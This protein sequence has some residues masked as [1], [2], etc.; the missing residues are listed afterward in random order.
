MKPLPNEISGELKDILLSM[1]NMDADK[2]P[3]VQQLLS[4]KFFYIIAS[5][6]KQ[7]RDKEQEKIKVEQENRKEKVRILQQKNREQEQQKRETQKQIEQE[8]IKNE[9]KLEQERIKN[10]EKLEQERIKNEELARQ[11]QQLKKEAEEHNIEDKALKKGLISP[12]LLKIIEEKLKIPLEGTEKE[13]KEILDVQESKLQTL[14]TVIKQNQDSPN[15]KEVIT[16][17]VI[18]ELNKILKDRDLNDMQSSISSIFV[19]LTTSVKLEVILLLQN[20]NPFPGLI[21]L[22]KHPNPQVVIDS[23]KTIYNILTNSSN[24]TDPTSHHPSFCMLKQCNGLNGIMTLF[25]ANISKESKDLAAISLSHVYRGKEIKNK[26]HK[27]I[28]AHLKT[29]IN[30]PNVQIKESAKNGL[31]DLAGNSINKAEIESNGFAI[32]K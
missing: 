6:Q 21:R 26:S 9:E 12:E 8:R 30:D 16:S 10:E 25:N 27:E 18:T 1:V 11:L 29:L 2:R 3:N 24:S 22:L 17:R 20:Q 4:S 14:L 28:I 15:K 13:K 23:T 32:P 7:I 19:E 5:Q 31:Q